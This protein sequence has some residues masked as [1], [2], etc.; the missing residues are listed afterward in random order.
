[1]DSFLNTTV[2]LSRGSISDDAV[3]NT[4]KYSFVI[5][6]VTWMAVYFMWKPRSEGAMMTANRLFSFE[7][8]LFARIRWCIW[9]REILAAADEKVR[10]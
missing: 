1:M 4:A 2:Q 7:P 6:A 5:V 8:S 9:A 10:L 3:S